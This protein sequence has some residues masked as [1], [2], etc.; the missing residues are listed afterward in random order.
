MSKSGKAN[1]LL[2]IK[3]VKKTS[4]GARFL[5]VSGRE[6]SSSQFD[7]TV[8]TTARHGNGGDC[9]ARESKAESPARRSLQFERKAV[10]RGY[11]CTIAC[12]PV[13]RHVI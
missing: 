3:Q 12:L 8:H 2:K 4:G 10:D 6:A 11:H 13:F 1:D 9:N 7:A 5:M